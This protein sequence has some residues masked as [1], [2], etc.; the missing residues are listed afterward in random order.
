MLIQLCSWV[1]HLVGVPN[2]QPPLPIDYLPRATHPVS[3]VPYHIAQYWD[4]GVRQRIEEKTLAL[5][6]ARKR[7]Q[8]KNGSA[9]GLCP[10]EVSRDLRESA[11]RLPV[12]KTWVRALEDPVRRYVIEQRGEKSDSSEDDDEE[13]ILFSG[14]NSTTLEKDSGWKRARKEMANGK[15]EVGMVYESQTEDDAA[16]LKYAL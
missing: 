2:A 3:D 5:Q 13:E 14:R 16:A 11:K 8:R 4:R 10:G 7:Q 9:T 1:D 12:V 6:S 15:V